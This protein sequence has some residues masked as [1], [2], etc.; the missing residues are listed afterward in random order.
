MPKPVGYS[1]YY[2]GDEMIRQPG[3]GRPK[4]PNVYDL[5]VIADEIDQFGF[6]LEGVPEWIKEKMTV[7]VQQSLR[8]NVFSKPISPGDMQAFEDEEL[9]EELTD[10]TGQAGL[11]INLNPVDIAK[12]PQKW[13]K[14]LAKG[15]WAELNPLGGDLEARKRQAL[16]AGAMGIGKNGEWATDAI[17]RQA[18]RRSGEGS[19]L[20]ADISDNPLNL[21]TAL[22]EYGKLGENVATKAADFEAN[23]KTALF[24][25]AKFDDVMRASLSG[26]KAVIADNIETLADNV[27]AD[28]AVAAI[29][30]SAKVDLAKHM[31]DTA[32]AVDDAV[33]AIKRLAQEDGALDKHGK[34]IE[35][36]KEIAKLNQQLAK[37]E[38]HIQ[39]MEQGRDALSRHQLELLGIAKGG[40]LVAGNIYASDLLDGVGPLLTADGL[41]RIHPQ[42]NGCRGILKNINQVATGHK[43]RGSSFGLRQLAEKLSTTTVNL[44]GNGASL[45]SLDFNSLERSLL[46][47]LS[48]EFTRGLI[49]G[50]EAAT[51]LE[52][53]YRGLS[54][55]GKEYMR[56]I[57]RLLP[58]LEKDRQFFAVDDFMDAMYS[59]DLFTKFL[60]AARLNPRLKALTPGYWTGEFMEKMHYFGLLVDEGSLLDANGNPINPKFFLY[61]WMNKFVMSR[62]GLANKFSIDIEGFGSHVVRG[63]HHFGAVKELHTLLKGDKISPQQLSLLMKA[64]SESDIRALLAGFVGPDEKKFFTDPEKLDRLAKQV[65]KLRDWVQKNAQRLGI[66]INKGEDLAK[67]LAGLMKYD[68]NKV[69]NIGIGITKAFRGKLQH[70]VQKLS[71]LQDKIFKS[72]AGKVVGKFLSWKTAISTAISEILMDAVVA[73]TGGVGVL[74]K[75]LEV[76]LQAAIRIILDIGEKVILSIL[77]A[78][79]GEL[80]KFLD[81]SLINVAKF[82]AQVTAVI[83]FAVAIPAMI[84]VTLLSGIPPVN[85]ANVGALGGAGAGGTGDG[86]GPTPRVLPPI[87]AGTCFFENNQGFLTYPSFGYNSSTG[88]YNNSCSGYYSPYYGHGTYAYSYCYNIPNLWFISQTSK[89]LTGCERVSRCSSS[90]AEAT[91]YFGMAADFARDYNAPSELSEVYLPELGNPNEDGDIIWNVVDTSFHNGFGAHV[92]LRRSDGENDYYMQI[93]HIVG[94]NNLTNGAELEAG[95]HIGRLYDLSG[96]RNHVHI[97]LEVDGEIRR[98]DYVFCTGE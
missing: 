72:F 52:D 21:T 64:G 62:D 37:T 47:Q 26:A 33:E 24:R 58:T 50:R 45:T 46:R 4:P 95:T 32:E 54:P 8:A 91:D 19:F 71:W 7:G 20:G 93:L 77:K 74:F 35:L 88:E 60:W 82:F 38:A 42:I 5:N 23:I 27:H 28:D 98:P 41:R 48:D 67:L 55:D 39:L 57:R 43:D 86:G 25:D 73:I 49:T 29:A 56:R 59:D 69:K 76:L 2:P 6:A 53:I 79:F 70:L 92:N 44:T 87:E 85:H 80:G 78:D 96:T 84:V 30:F 3:G 66:D 11:S 75:P 1:G 13:A 10:I 14:K 61:K 12:D 51:R 68:A 34:P 63:G 17:K 90:A 97:E 16:W 9:E 36:D 81:K 31:E 65:K 18:I 22:G 40:N 94:N 83:V 89:M 15:T